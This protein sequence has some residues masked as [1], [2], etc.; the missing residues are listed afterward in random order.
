MSKQNVLE[1]SGIS[2]S[3]GPTKAL[4]NVSLHVAAGECLG[5]VGRNG[6]G[7][8]TVV[9]ILTGL[10]KSESGTV[11]FL[12]QDAPPGGNPAAW[13]EYVSCVYQHSMLVPT[14]TVA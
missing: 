11:R 13:Q 14:L 2:M 10:R 12:G 6:A 9:S 7:K 5:I 1:A 4:D 8:S 3:F